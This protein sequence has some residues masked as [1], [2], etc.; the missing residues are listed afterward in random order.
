MDYFDFSKLAYGKDNKTLNIY[1]KIN[2]TYQLTFNF[3]LPNKVITT[4]IDESGLFY[5]VTV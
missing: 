2:G 3:I 4:V 1:E 5:H